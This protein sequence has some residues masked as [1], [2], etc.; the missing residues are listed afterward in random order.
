MNLCLN[1]SKTCPALQ[2]FLDARTCRKRKNLRFHQLE[3]T[4][5]Q[6]AFPGVGVQTLSRRLQS[7]ALS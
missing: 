6:I 1:K 5:N 4:L 7:V 3:M 2:T